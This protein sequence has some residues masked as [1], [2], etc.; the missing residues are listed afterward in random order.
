MRSFELSGEAQ[1]LGVLLQKALA[2]F[3]A[4]KIKSTAPEEREREKYFL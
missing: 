3:R 2:L 1:L 4:K